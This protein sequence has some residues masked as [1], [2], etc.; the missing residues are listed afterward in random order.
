MWT[1]T[2]NVRDLRSLPGDYTSEAS[3][4]NNNGDVVATAKGPRGM[5]AFLWTTTTGM[6]ELGVLPGGDSSRALAISNFEEVVGSSTNESGDHAFIWTKQAGMVDL[7][8]AS[9]AALGI[10]LFEAH[11][12][13]DK[14]QIIAMGGSVQDHGMGT[15]LR[16]TATQEY[17]PAPSATF[18][19]TPTT[20]P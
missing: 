20:T 2:G 15:I 19:L 9:T 8:N 1:K 7:N 10:V 16:S 3:A 11:S 18:L 6:Q 12:I 4:I 13:N 14:G 5:R 17:A